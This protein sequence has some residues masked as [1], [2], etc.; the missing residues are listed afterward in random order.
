MHCLVGLVISPF[1]L[2]VHHILGAKQVCQRKTSEDCP[3]DS[4]SS[5]GLAEWISLWGEVLALLGFLT[6]CLCVVS[7]LP[8]YQ[9]ANVYCTWPGM[10]EQQALGLVGGAV[11][12]AAAVAQQ[13]LGCHTGG[14]HDPA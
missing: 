8:S 5:S 2:G 11:L 14:H 12:S 9:T 1:W 3:R 4:Q 6:S 10:Q 13:I 7:Q